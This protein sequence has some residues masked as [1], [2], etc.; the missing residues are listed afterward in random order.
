MLD[1]LLQKEN[2][3]EDDI[4]VKRSEVPICWYENKNGKKCRYYV[5][6]FIPSQNRCIEAKST[7]TAKKKMDNIF[8]KQNAL[9]DA[10]Y[11]CEIW[12]Y[13]SKGEKVQCYK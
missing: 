5:D 7:W 2:V 13:N 3:C 10:G 6:C 1:D 9:K 11:I 8:L 4:I 12:I